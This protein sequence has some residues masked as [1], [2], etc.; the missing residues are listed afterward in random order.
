[1]IS[2]LGQARDA[3]PNV[4]L[5]ALKPGEP[6]PDTNGLID[7]RRPGGA[8]DRRV[9]GRLDRRGRL[10]NPHAR[11]LIGRASPQAR[12]SQRREAGA[13]QQP[14][15]ARVVMLGGCVRLT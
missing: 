2:F 15:P 12:R 6:L 1:M 4:A 11:R 7:E 13:G 8:R 5:G 14:A 9:A 10:A 3:I